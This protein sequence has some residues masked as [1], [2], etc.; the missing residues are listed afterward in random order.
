MGINNFF[1]DFEYSASSKG[2]WIYERMFLQL[3]DCKNI[4]KDLCPGIYLIFL[5]NH[6][7]GDDIVRE[8]RLNVMNT[9]SGFVGEQ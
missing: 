5:F 8:E 4:L 9:N 3:E 1:Q 7:C 6:P 2:Y